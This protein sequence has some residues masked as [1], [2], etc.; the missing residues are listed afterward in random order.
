[1]GGMD[2]VSRQKIKSSIIWY[3]MFFIYKHNVHKLNEAQISRKTLHIL[4]IFLTL[5]IAF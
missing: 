3:Y 4:S 5:M 2:P 1:M